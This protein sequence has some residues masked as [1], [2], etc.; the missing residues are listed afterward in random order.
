MAVLAGNAG[1]FRLSTNTVAEIDTWTLDV[2]TGLEE[3]QSF[4]DTW[5]ERTA[6]IREWSGTA[7]GRFDNTD[8]NGHVALNTAFLGGTTVSARFYINGTNYYSGTAFVQASVSAAE[9]GLVTVSYT[10]TGSGSLS[11]T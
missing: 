3:T 11:Y 8:T 4:G 9:N 2:S 10:I 7:A 1:S 5:K 6:T